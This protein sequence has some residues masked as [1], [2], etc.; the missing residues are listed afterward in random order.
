MDKQ[1]DGQVFRGRIAELIEDHESKVE[2]TQPESTAR[3]LLMMNSLKRL[4]PITK[5]CSISL[6]IKS[7]T[8]CLMWKFKHIISHEGPQQKG[9]PDYR[10]SQ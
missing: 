10:N 9:H 1:E 3:Y 7:Q 8:S 4:S 5:C 2:E 6:R